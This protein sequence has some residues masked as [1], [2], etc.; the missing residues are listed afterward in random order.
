MEHR[1][2]LKARAVV[3]K[4]LPTHLHNDWFQIKFWL[5]ARVAYVL[6]MQSACI[7]KY[8]LHQ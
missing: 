7:S 8:V 2:T 3:E 4:K 5:Q 6:S 1:G